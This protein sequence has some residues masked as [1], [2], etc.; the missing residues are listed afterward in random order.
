MVCLA[1]ES[2]C[3]LTLGMVRLDCLRT[4]AGYGDFRG[5]ERFRAALAGMMETTFVHA[6]VD[7]DAVLVQAGCSAI[8]DSLA[9]CLGEEGDACIVPA[10]VYPAF[11]NDF[12][13]RARVHLKMAQTHHPDYSLTREVLDQ[14]YGECLS[15]GKPPKMLLLCNPCNPTGRVYS[16]ETLEMCVR[17]AEERGIHLISDEI[18]A[19]SLFPGEA[20]VSVARVCADLHSGTRGDRYLGDFVHITYGLSKDWAM[21]GVRG[22]VLFTHNDKL[23]AAVSNLACFNGMSSYAQWVWTCVFEDRAWVT[24]YIRTNQ[25][26]LR[27]CYA[28]LEEALACVDVPVTPCQGTL[29]AWADFR[30]HLKEQSWAGELALWK[31]LFARSKILLTTGQSCHSAVPGFFRVCF[32]WPA[33]TPDDPTAAMR[34][35]K[36]RLLKHF[37]N[38]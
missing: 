35:L 22:G 4:Q 30:R 26:K 20:F 3:S 23:T 14:A 12:W 11:A 21:S 36:S 29:M 15:E 38:A 37:A 1:R 34:V 24:H 2:L 13:A 5:E 10:P 17:W 9:W 18:Y 33:V 6:P 16:R 19:N 32:A 27:A 25:E 31:D 8:L 7:K 28:A